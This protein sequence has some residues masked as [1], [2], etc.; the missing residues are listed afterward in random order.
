VTVLEIPFAGFFDIDLKGRFWDKANARL[1]SSSINR[2][3]TSVGFAYL[4]SGWYSKEN[5]AYVQRSYGFSVRT[6]RK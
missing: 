4:D 1:W 6:F 2:G 5:Y 3:S